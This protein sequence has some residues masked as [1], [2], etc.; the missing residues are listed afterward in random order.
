MSSLQAA[1]RHLYFRWFGAILL[2]SGLF[3][4]LR[5]AFAI[6]DD[7]A[8][9]KQLLSLATCVFALASF[10]VNHDTAVAYALRSQEEGVMLSDYP[11]LNQELKEE[12]DKDRREAA[13]LKPF[14]IVSYVLPSCTLILQCYLWL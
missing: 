2:V 1:I 6:F 5:Y 3:L 14:P 10:G 8:F 4:F 12:L 13:L 7:C 9:V 11:M